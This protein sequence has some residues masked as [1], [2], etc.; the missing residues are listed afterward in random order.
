[1]SFVIE[2]P[3]QVSIPVADTTSLFPVRRVYCVGRNYAEHAIEMGHD[4]NREP[5]F[6]FCKPTDA[7][8]VIPSDAVTDIP[9]PPKT[10]NLH[11][12]VELVV[13]I[14]KSGKNIDVQNAMDHVYGYAVGLDLTRRDLQQDMKDLARPWELGKAFDASAPVSSIVPKGKIENIQNIDIN[15][16]LNDDIKQNGNTNQMIWSIAECISYLSQYFDLQGGDLIFTGTPSGV[17]AVNVNDVLTASADQIG[18]FKVKFV[19]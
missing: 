12:E 19:G 10:N 15:L 1:M 3:Q 11:F 18:Q 2:P 17:G 7:I 8:R 14:S 4:P 6:F 5:P 9:Y 13:A 16:R